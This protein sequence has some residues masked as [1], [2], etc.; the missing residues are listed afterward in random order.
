MIGYA[1]GGYHSRVFVIGYADVDI[2]VE[3]L[4]LS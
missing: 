3:Y 2:I 1:G 4:R